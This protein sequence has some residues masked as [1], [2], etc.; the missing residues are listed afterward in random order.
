MK[1]MNGFATVWAHWKGLKKLAMSIVF[2]TPF[3][4]MWVECI[5]R[6]ESV[7]SP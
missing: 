7:L 1:S 3:I 5:A 2:L 6:L 4:K